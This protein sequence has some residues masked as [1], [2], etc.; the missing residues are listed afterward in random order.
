M[1]KRQPPCASVYQRNTSMA[2]RDSQCGRVY[3]HHTVMAK[4]HPHYARVYQQGQE[5]HAMCQCVPTP[6]RQPL[7]ITTMWHPVMA[8]R[9]LKCTRMFLHLIDMAKNNHN[10]PQCKYTRLTLAG[11]PLSVKECNY[12][13]ILKILP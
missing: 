6:Y 8:K 1:C 5:R 12:T 4:R 9:Q 2:K 10:V 13:S 11:C 7:Q 3:R